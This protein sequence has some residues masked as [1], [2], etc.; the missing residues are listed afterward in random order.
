MSRTRQQR[1]GH[2][3]R[4]IRVAE[5]WAACDGPQGHRLVR[6]FRVADG[7]VVFSPGLAGLVL[8]SFAG[9]PVP[10]ITSGSELDSLT[11][12]E[13]EVCGLSQV[14]YRE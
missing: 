7:D 8:D 4:R 10:G 1:C 11:P 13:M 9:K 5:F 6:Q 14:T 12:R 2:P 3:H